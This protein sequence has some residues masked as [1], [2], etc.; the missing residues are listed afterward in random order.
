[1]DKAVKL[2]SSSHCH[3]AFRFSLFCGIIIQ[4]G[5]HLYLCCIMSI[6]LGVCTMLVAL[7]L[8]EFA[9]DRIKIGRTVLHFHRIKCPEPLECECIGGLISDLYERLILCIVAYVQ[10]K[11][12]NFW[13]QKVC[14]LQ[15]N[16]GF[17]WKVIQK[18]WRIHRII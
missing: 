12:D 4:L 1:M 11:N 14:L 17:Y 6:S 5:M 9:Q 15:V 18:C 13:L 3:L 16:G 8:Y 7:K 2:F 10:Q